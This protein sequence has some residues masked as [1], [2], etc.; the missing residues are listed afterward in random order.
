MAAGGHDDDFSSVIRDALMDVVPA[1][2]FDA[3]TCCKVVYQG[4]VDEFAR[5]SRVAQITAFRI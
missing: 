4:F 2:F 3:A 1:G 5:W